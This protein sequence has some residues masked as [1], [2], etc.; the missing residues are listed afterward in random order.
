MTTLVAPAKL[1]WFLEVTGRRAD[2]YHEL[3]SEMFSLGLRRRP[4]GRRGRRLLRVEGP[5]GQ[6]ARATGRPGLPGPRAVVRARAA[7]A[8]KVIPVGG[9][10]GGGS[11]DAAAILRWAGGVDRERAW[12]SAATYRSARWADGRS[13]KGSASG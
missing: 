1:T 8:D 4:R 10:L 9:G 13:S 5:S 12:A 7:C 2:G 3:R 6:G 11:T